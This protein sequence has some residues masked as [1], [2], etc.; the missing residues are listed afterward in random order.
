MVEEKVQELKEKHFK[1]FKKQFKYYQDMFEINDFSVA[2]QFKELDHKYANLIVACVSR[3]AV[4]SLNKR[5]CPIVELTDQQLDK[6]ALHE[7]CHL[8]LADLETLVSSVF[9]TETEYELIKERTVNK[10]A[11]VVKILL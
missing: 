3:V 11:H 6:I 2:F 4:C 1:F 9:K 7:C 5:W 8:L 10:L